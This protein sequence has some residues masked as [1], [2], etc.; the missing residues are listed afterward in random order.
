MNNVV[1]YEYVDTAVNNWLR[2]AAQMPVP[3]GD[4]VGLVVETACTYHA[5]LSWPERIDA[6]LCVT[7]IGRSSITYGIGLFSEGS[8]DAAGEARFTHVY[9]DEKTRRPV[10]IPQTLRKAAEQIL[11]PGQN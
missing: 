10:E 9:V 1:Y 5:S 6:G 3:H 4:I 7:K 8:D 11:R 2:H